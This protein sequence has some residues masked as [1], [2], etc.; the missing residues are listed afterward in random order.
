[1]VSPSDVSSSF[2]LLSFY[3]SFL[4]LIILFNFL[5]IPISSPTPPPPLFSYATFTITFPLLLLN[6]SVPPPHFIKANCVSGKLHQ[7]VHK[8]LDI[9]PCTTEKQFVNATNNPKFVDYK[10]IS[11]STCLLFS[12]G[13]IVEN[14]NIISIPG[15]SS[16][17]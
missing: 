13:R 9:R 8:F 4:L 3:I 12:D 1:M 14:S 7:A 6:T 10:F 2:F 5:V 17:F 15:L 16:S 11:P